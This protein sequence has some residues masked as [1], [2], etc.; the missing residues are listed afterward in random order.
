MVPCEFESFEHNRCWNIWLQTILFECSDSILE[1]KALF[2]ELEKKNRGAN[3]W[4]STSVSLISQNSNS[5]SK[6][7]FY[8]IQIHLHHL[9]HGDSE[10]VKT[11]PQNTL[12]PTKIKQIP[13]TW[14]CV[15]HK[16]FIVHFGRF[17]KVSKPSK[18]SCILSAALRCV[19]CHFAWIAAQPQSQ[20]SV[21]R[22]ECNAMGKK[23]RPLENCAIVIV[24]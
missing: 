6:A 18:V 8:E 14:L 24:V 13:N 2:L 3:P 12:T 11:S 1:F 9:L 21:I 5:K 10:I 23:R 4:R 19:N 7:S 16:H 20:P 22:N 17:P 15:E